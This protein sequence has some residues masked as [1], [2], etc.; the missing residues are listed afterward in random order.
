MKHDDCFVYAPQPPH[1]HLAARPACPAARLPTPPAC[2]P[3]L[4]LKALMLTLGAIEDVAARPVGPTPEE[5]AA[6]VAAAA[7]AAAHAPPP[8]A[9]Q[10]R[11]AAAARS[12]ARPPARPPA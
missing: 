12:L 10:A 9:S 8:A 1:A 3:Q 2:L 11:P 6:L 7:A 5:L 4:L